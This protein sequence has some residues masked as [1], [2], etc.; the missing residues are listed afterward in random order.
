MSGNI[1]ADAVILVIGQ[2]V[3]YVDG[4][5][6]L[7]TQSFSIWWVGGEVQKHIIL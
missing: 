3:K 2:L 5:S 7:P 6:N 1:Y 4:Q